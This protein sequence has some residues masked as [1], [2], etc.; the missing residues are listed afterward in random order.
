MKT[1]PKFNNGLN[2]QLPVK[3][4]ECDPMAEAFGGMGAGIV[5]FKDEKGNAIEDVKLVEA[6]SLNGLG[7]ITH[8]SSGVWSF[9]GSD[10]GK[11]FKITLP[12]YE[13]NEFTANA[14]VKPVNITLKKQAKSYQSFIKPVPDQRPMTANEVKITRL[15]DNR[16]ITPVF[17]AG[18]TFKFVGSDV[19]KQFR[20]EPK[21]AGMFIP[22]TITT[23]ANAMPIYHET[24]QLRS[25]IKITPTGK[26]LRVIGLNSVVGLGWAHEPGKQAIGCNQLGIPLVALKDGYLPTTVMFDEV[27]R[28]YTVVLKTESKSRVFTPMRVVVGVLTI[29]TAFKLLKKKK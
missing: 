3:N 18:E 12:G 5:Y 24:K 8:N 14:N 21:I 7:A 10:V 27:G 28:S 11:R 17:E 20:I 22:I 1:R 15:S 2:S 9:T 4:G 26:D 25:S 16:V 13:S 23:S 6:S 29:Y 19:G